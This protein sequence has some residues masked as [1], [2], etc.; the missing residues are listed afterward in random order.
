MIV[1]AMPF[2]IGKKVAP[3]DGSTVVFSITGHLPREFSVLVLERRA[4]LFDDIPPIPRS[5]SR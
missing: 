1:D 4:A 5:G 3:P 2:V